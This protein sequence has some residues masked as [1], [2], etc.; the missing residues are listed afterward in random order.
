MYALEP[1]HSN[2]LEC[3][4]RLLQGGY[5]YE[6]YECAAWSGETTLNFYSAESERYASRICQVGDSLVK[7]YSIDNILKGRKATYIKYDVER[8]G[9]E[10][11]KGSI[12]TIRRY[13]PRLAI[14]VYHKPKDILGIP[15]F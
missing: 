9:L 8:S 6:L 13:R 11:L 15:D 5:K 14:A 12:K 3:D 2:Y 10:A 1:D 7:A 4:R